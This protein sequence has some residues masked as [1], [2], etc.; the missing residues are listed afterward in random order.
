[1]IIIIMFDIWLFF[2]LKGGVV[3]VLLKFVFKKKEEEKK[4][5]GSGFIFGFGR[6]VMGC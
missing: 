1:M 4:G 5:C 6:V 2:V 3:V